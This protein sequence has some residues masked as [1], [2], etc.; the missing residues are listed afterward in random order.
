MPQLPST[1]AAVASERTLP[2]LF[3]VGAAPQ[4]PSLAPPVFAW[5]GASPRPL[6]GF[7][8][9]PFHGACFYN[10]WRV[11]RM[12]NR[13]SEATISVSEYDKEPP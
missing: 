9:R 13:R 7:G 10:L 6:L 8:S 12:Q 1:E 4:P 2:P 5:E 3:T 11:S